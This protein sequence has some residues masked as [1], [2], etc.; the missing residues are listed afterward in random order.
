M[1]SVSKRLRFASPIWLL[2]ALLLVIAPPASAVRPFVTDDARVVGGR[3]AQLETWLRGD[4]GAF[5]QWALV[6][7]GPIEPLEITVGAVHGV[8]YSSA[9]QYS[10]AGPLV[11]AKYLLRTWKP[12]SWP[13]LAIS[14]GAFAPAGTGAFKVHGW[15]SFVYA[16]V[17]ESLFDDDRV[18]VHGNAGVVRSSAGKV[19][20]TWGVG[21][22]IRVRGSFHAVAEIFSGDPYTETSGNAFQAGFRHVISERVQV[23]T[24]IG[25][26]I[27]GEVP[28]PVWASVGIRLV[29]PQLW[30]R[31]KKN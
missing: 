15:D 4:K 7:F 20:P 27:S 1:S 2:S 22:Q 24:T 5:Q 25:S 29:S 28:M 6:A 17:T 8:T 13:G 9:T 18:L 12:N 10:V 16:A 3:L 31:R 23:D 11:Q 21:S 14:G 26:G 19:K 30:R